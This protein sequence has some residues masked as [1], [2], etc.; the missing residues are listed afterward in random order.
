MV[1]NCHNSYNVRGCLPCALKCSL[2][3]LVAK[4]EKRKRKTF[5]LIKSIN[6]IQN[7]L[8]EL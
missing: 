3:P 1:L 8:P 5:Y 2:A 4:N 6:P 7:F